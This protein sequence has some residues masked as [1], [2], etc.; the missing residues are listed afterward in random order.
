MAAAYKIAKQ[1]QELKNKSSGTIEFPVV[2][3]AANSGW[4]S[5]VVKRE[6]KNLQWTS[7]DGSDGKLKQS[8]VLVEFS[9]LALHFEMNKDPCEADL[10]D[11]QNYLYKRSVARE[12]AELE[13]LKGLFNAFRKV[14]FLAG[15]MPNEKEETKNFEV[16]IITRFSLENQRAHK[17]AKN[18]Y[19]N[20]T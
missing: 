15:N 19:V 11:I 3:V 20:Y 7:Y 18:I 10:Q 14:S 1:T 6:L 4:E 17:I 2:Q 9:E 12:M 13:N 16:C 8:G 5:G